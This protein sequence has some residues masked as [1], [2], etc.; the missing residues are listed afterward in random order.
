MEVLGVECLEVALL[1]IEVRVVFLIALRE[2][3]IEGVLLPLLAQHLADVEVQKW[4]MRHLQGDF[5]PFR[6]ALKGL[7]H[8]LLQ[9]LLAGGRRRGKSAT[10]SAV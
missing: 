5:L 4:L 8:E 7:L 10:I 9:E 6:L 2:V 3:A 1:V